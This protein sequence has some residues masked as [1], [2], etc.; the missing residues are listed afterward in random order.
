MWA[1]SSLWFLAVYFYKIIVE[2]K[3]G[4]VFENS[5]FLEFETVGWGFFVLGTILFIITDVA[6]LG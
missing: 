3:E 2:Q 4:L 6:V 5:Y 1:H